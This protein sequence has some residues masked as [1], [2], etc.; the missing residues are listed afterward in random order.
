MSTRIDPAGGRG[1]VAVVEVTL[2]PSVGVATAG[3]GEAN[4]GREDVNVAG[5]V[6]EEP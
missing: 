2:A 6:V 5:A 4:D 3:D 1:S